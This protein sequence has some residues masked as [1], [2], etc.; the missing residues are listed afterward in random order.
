[1]FIFG[2]IPSCMHC[3]FFFFLFFSC[4]FW[5]QELTALTSSRFHQR[6][7]FFSEA[8]SPTVVS[9][10]LKSGFT[11]NLS[12][13]VQRFTIYIFL[14]IY[15]TFNLFTLGVLTCCNCMTM[16]EPYIA[17]GRYPTF[18][19]AKSNLQETDDLDLLREKARRETRLEMSRCFWFQED[20]KSSLKPLCFLGFAASS[21]K[22]ISTV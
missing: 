7:G 10:Q 21:F 16:L 20:V 1:M 11:T 19:L 15:T 12:W 4:F 18:S 14:I 6:R 2:G 17:T 3:F 9:A 22:M 13:M 8:R 5:L